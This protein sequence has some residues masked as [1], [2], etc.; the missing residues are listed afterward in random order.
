METLDRFQET[1]ALRRRQREL[2]INLDFMTYEQILELQQRIGV[3][4]KRVNVEKI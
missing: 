4:P 2:Q 3:V 1:R